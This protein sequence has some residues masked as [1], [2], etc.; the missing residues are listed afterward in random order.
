MG[1]WKALRGVAASV[2]CIAACS[3]IALAGTAASFA[4]AKPPAIERTPVRSSDLS[5][6]G[7]DP[8]SRILEIEFRSGGIYRYLDVP[9]EVFDGLLAA[10]SKGRFFAKEIR[11]R[12]RFERL[13][14]R[15]GAAR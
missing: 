12:Y 15:P 4:G 8:K 1:A 11:D 3:V 10:K 7:Y 14:S 6:V 9:K 5:S 13:N 2:L